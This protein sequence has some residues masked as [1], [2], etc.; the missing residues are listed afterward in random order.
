[1]QQVGYGI[2]HAAAGCFQ[3]L[4]ILVTTGKQHAVRADCRRDLCVMQ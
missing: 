3:S 2:E 1:M 4:T